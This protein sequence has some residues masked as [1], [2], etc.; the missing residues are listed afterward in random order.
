MKTVRC[1]RRCLVVQFSPGA[2]SLYA[3]GSAVPEYDPNTEFAEDTCKRPDINARRDLDVAA[4]FPAVA[5]E[6]FGCAFEIQASVP[7]I[8]NVRI[9]TYRMLLCRNC[10]ASDD[11]I[12]LPSS[13]LY[14]DRRG[15]KRTHRSRHLACS[16]SIC[17]WV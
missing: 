2:I 15:Q 1:P 10:H 8:M 13:C 5:S 7:G 14:R 12:A 17:S 3:M 4:V 9:H 6:A 16:L 11:W